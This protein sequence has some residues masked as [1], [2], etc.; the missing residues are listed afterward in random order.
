MILKLK[1]SLLF[2]IASVL[3]FSCQKEYS[4]EGSVVGGGTAVFTF[5]GA[6]TA[7]GAFLTFGTGAVS[8]I[9]STA[10]TLYSAG[11]FSGGDQAVV[12]TNTVTISYSAG[13]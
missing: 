9:D 8:T 5:T 1:S 7:K 12:N 11:L 6:G 13:I 2:I 10:A 3:I 4:V